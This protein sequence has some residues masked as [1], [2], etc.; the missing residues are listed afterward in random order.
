[1][2]LLLFFFFLWL[3]QQ[4][5]GDDKFVYSGFADSSKLILDGAAMVTPDGLLD[6]TNGSARL[7][8]HATHPTPL[9]FRDGVSS[10]VQSFSISFV[11]GIISPRP[12]N[13][14][15]LFISPGKNFSDALPTQYLG[16]L[17]DRNDGAETNRVFAVELDTI[18]N[19]EFQDIDDNHVGVDINSLRSVRSHPA[20]YYDGQGVFKNLSLVNGGP[21]Q[22][23]VDHDR[24]ATR[25][26]VTMAPLSFAIARPS[27]PLISADCN[28]SAVIT[29]LAYVGFSSAAGKANARHYVLGWSLAMNGPAPAIDTTKLPKMPVGRV[30]GSKDWSKVIEIVAPLATAAF[31]LTVGGTILVLATR[32]QRYK[33]LRE[34]WEVEFGP[35]RFSYKDLFRATEGFRNKN[36]LGSGGFGRVYKGV[37]PRSSLEVAVKRVSH[38]STQ[39]MKEFITEVVSIGHLQHRN[40]VPLLGYCRRNDELLVYEFMPNGGLDKYLF[41]EDGKPALSWAQRVGIIKDIASSLL[42]LHHECEK[43]IVH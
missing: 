23:W 1:M 37:L 5:H 21:M 42:Y 29:E 28:L 22:V 27:R 36:L 26:D 24:A 7:K 15:A 39:G 16:L 20:G 3:I 35:H 13:G 8:G 18:Q 30:L 19:S 14:F 9:R 40:L 41:S 2:K 25:V 11:F 32:Y 10:P 43:V 31:I 12:S 34:D 38:N 33:E 17:G 6:L 4:V